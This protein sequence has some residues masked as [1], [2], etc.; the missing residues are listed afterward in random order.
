MSGLPP[1]RDQKT[2]LLET[3]KRDGSWVATPVSI[4][5]EGERAFFRT[6][7]ASGNTTTDYTDAAQLYRSARAGG[8][9]VR[10]LADCLVA[11]VALRHGAE[12]W[13]KV[14]LPR[15]AWGNRLFGVS[16]G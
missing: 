7:D 1:F 15:W 11:A 2:V 12:I 6:Y 4:V 9:T 13:H 8:M 10:K 16:A 14:A 5:V 3:Q